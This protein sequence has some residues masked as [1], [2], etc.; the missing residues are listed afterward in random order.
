MNNQ[1]NLD[2]T[3]MVTYAVSSKYPDTCLDTVG[4]RTHIGSDTLRLIIEQNGVPSRVH[5]VKRISEVF[6]IEY[7]ELYAAYLRQGFPETLKWIQEFDI[8]DC[9]FKDLMKYYRLVNGLTRDNM[10]RVLGV[11]PRG[12]SKRYERNVR[13]PTPQTLADMSSKL[14]ISLDILSRSIYKQK[15]MHYNPFRYGNVNAMGVDINSPY[16]IPKNTLLNKAIIDILE[17]LDISYAKFAREVKIHTG[18]FV[19]STFNNEVM[20]LHK[21]PVVAAY[22]NIDMSSMVDSYR[23]SME[24]SYLSTNF[25]NLI[26]VVCAYLG[27]SIDSF[28]TKIVKMSS[29]TLRDY[30]EGVRFPSKRFIPV[31]SR[32]LGIEIDTLINMFSTA[33]NYDYIKP[34]A[35]ECVRFVVQH[36]WDKLNNLTVHTLLQLFHE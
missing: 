16:V 1:I 18:N 15:S 27:M 26:F 36:N 33:C 3:N 4:K 30:M 21:L 19:G 14:G 17:E 24:F 22:L 12:S 25:G 35:I 5:T 23:L 29:S 9:I 13:M 6:D 2:F 7:L 8:N 11:Q 31:I 34:Y 28:I 10:D 20:Y 32:T